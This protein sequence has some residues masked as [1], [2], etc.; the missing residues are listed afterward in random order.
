MS[1]DATVFFT[2]TFGMIGQAIESYGL[3]GSGSSAFF[4][5]PSYDSAT[6]HFHVRY[7]HLGDHF[8]DNVDAVGFVRDDDRREVDSA[9]EKVFW[10]DS[11]V[12]ERVQYR[13]NYNAYWEMGG[14]LRSRSSL[15]CGRQRWVWP[16][17]NP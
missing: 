9:V 16:A 6:G 12:V 7:T 15:H 1:V 4:L 8:A 2:P 5:R 3:F 17:A 10:L 11:G 14:G 13:S